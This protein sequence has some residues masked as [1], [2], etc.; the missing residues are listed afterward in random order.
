MQFYEPH[1]TLGDDDAHHTAEILSIVDDDF[2]LVLSS[3]FVLSRHHKVMK[4]V[5][6]FSGGDSS[7]APLEARPHLRI[8][9]N[10]RLLFGGTRSHAT[11][12]IHAAANVREN[13]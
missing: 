3:R 12:I 10:Y 2:P 9:G 13:A 1:R 5:P 11:A 7:E 6:G 8:I 4:V